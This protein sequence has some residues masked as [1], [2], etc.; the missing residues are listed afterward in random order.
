MELVR[1]P[2][3]TRVRLSVWQDG[4]WLGINFKVTS[5]T[6]STIQRKLSVNGYGEFY[7]AEITRAVADEACARW[8]ELVA[9]LSEQDREV[10]R[11]CTEC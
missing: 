8:H 3:S 2:H 1:Q 5:Q 10:L 11:R 4:M 6:L 7:E 9:A